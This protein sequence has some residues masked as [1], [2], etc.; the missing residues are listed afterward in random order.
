MLPDLHLLVELD[1]WAPQE[2]ASEAFVLLE[3]FLAAH[4]NITVSLLSW[5]ALRPGLERLATAGDWSFPDH[6]IAEGGLAIFHARAS[7]AWVEDTGYRRW[8]GARWD[9]LA[10]QRAVLSRPS[11]SFRQILG[12]G[13]ARRAVFKVEPDRNLVQAVAELEDCLARTPYS[14]RIAL[15]GDT[16]E[17]VP[18]DV[19]PRTAAAFLHERLARPCPL[20]ACGSSPRFQEVLRLAELPVRLTGGPEEVLE[21]LFRVQ[22]HPSGQEGVKV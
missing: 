13:S 6:F 10:L 17:V 12:E 21:A 8:V 4:G 22:V 18:Q 2:G 1:C 14:A 16:F 19:G 7:G 9:P 15:D 5:E 3:T 11:Y 20:M